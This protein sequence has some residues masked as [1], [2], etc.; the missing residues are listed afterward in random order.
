MSIARELALLLS[1]GG[2]VGR[3][4]RLL[5]P[6]VTSLEVY[7]PYDE[8]PEEREPVVACL[9]DDLVSAY[10]DAF[11]AL[12]AHRQRLIGP[13]SA[14]WRWRFDLGSHWGRHLT[15]ASRAIH[16]LIWDYRVFSGDSRVRE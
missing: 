11:R 7:D 8:A 6:Y 4:H 14:L 3:I 13:T 9:P 1:A 2:L 5:D 12:D 10:E 15:D 16:H